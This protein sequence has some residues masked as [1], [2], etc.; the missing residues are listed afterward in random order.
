MRPEVFLTQMEG[1]GTV[2]LGGPLH[3]NVHPIVK[4]TRTMSAVS[5]R[6]SVGMPAYVILH[7]RWETLG[8][9]A[10]GKKCDWPTNGSHFIHHKA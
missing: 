6:D 4:Q 2:R 9:A 5:M 1:V 7:V 3:V 10:S 8:P